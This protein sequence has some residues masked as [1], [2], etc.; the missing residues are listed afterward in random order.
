MFLM[1]IRILTKFRLQT[2]FHR[3]MSVFWTTKFRQNW[4]TLSSP[5]TFLELKLHLFCCCWSMIVV[6]FPMTL[7]Q[8]RWNKILIPK[9]PGCK[10]CFNPLDAFWKYQKIRADRN[11]NKSWKFSTEPISIGFI[12]FQP[13]WKVETPPLRDGLEFSR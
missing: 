12:K 1:L 9:S 2:H 11:L 4:L 10:I 6:F 7:L 5:H 8:K 13:F 3:N